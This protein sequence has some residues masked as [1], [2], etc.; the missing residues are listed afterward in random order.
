MAISINLTRILSFPQLPGRAA[1]ALLILLS[2]LAFSTLGLT[3]HISVRVFAVGL[4]V[5]WAFLFGMVTR[6]ELGARRHG[7]QRRWWVA[8]LITGQLPPLTILATA[9]SLWT[10]MGGGVYWLVPATL[11]GFTGGV[12]NAWILLV[13]IQR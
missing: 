2:V 3:P 13:E 1:E 4:I 9:V 11:L 8:R 5:I 7:G 12:I 10:G 6:I